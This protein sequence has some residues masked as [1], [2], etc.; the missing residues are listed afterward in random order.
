MLD[1]YFMSFNIFRW[2]SK[3]DMLERLL[4][5]RP[6]CKNYASTDPKVQLTDE[7]WERIESVC[8]VL[9]PAKIATKELQD[10]QLTAGF[11]FKITSTIQ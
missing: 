9:L 10:E 8:K 11:I 3:H 7:M 2:H 4:K 6:F 5:L 1:K